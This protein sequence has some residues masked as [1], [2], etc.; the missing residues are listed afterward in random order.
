MEE[1]ERKMREKNSERKGREMTHCILGALI[2][3]ATASRGF[4]RS[5]ERTAENV[6][7]AMAKFR[8]SCQGFCTLVFLATAEETKRRRTQNT[9]PKKQERKRKYIYIQMRQAWAHDE[10]YCL[11]RRGRD[12]GRAE[13]YTLIAKWVYFVRLFVVYLRTYTCSGYSLARKLEENKEGFAS[14]VQ[15]EFISAASPW[16]MTE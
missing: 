2:P 13:K 1:R 10:R 15:N 14:D 4:S 3:T 8:K 11:Q 9:K 16:S 5:R 6:G 7:N 12:K